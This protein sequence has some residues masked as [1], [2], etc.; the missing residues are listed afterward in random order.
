M[1]TRDVA[2]W[3]V[4]ALV[5]AAIVALVALAQGTPDHGRDLGDA[6]TTAAATSM[7]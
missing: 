6:P 7:P 4:A 2:N 1:E 5:V 3:V